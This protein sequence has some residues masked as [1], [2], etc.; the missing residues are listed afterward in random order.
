MKSQFLCLLPGPSFQ[1]SIN[2]FTK[3]NVSFRHQDTN[4]GMIWDLI[5]DIF[6]LDSFFFSRNLSCRWFRIKM[7]FGRLSI[8]MWHLYF[9]VLFPY[10]YN[11]WLFACS[12][13]DS[14][15]LCSSFIF[16]RF[17]L[18]LCN[19]QMMTKIRLLSSFPDVFSH[20][21]ATVLFQGLQTNYC[22]LFS[23]FSLSTY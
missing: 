16:F 2:F 21:S 18:L 17:S 3:D 12:F 22:L 1:V 7:T 14:F 11:H 15:S 19:L 13:S 10:I 6:Q 9:I 20:A 5:V 8:L 23:A 4:S